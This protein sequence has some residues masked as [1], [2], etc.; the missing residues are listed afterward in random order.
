MGGGLGEYWK[1]KYTSN[2]LLI[3]M[4]HKYLFLASKILWIPM[5]KKWGSWPLQE[6]KK[7]ELVGG[8]FWDISCQSTKETNWVLGGKCQAEDR[9]RLPCPK[10]LAELKGRSLP[11]CLGTL[12]TPRLQEDFCGERASKCYVTDERDLLQIARMQFLF[13]VTLNNTV[14]LINIKIHTY[15]TGLEKVNH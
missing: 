4:T 1:G 3:S 14:L 15:T 2:H 9:L 10:S 6:R 7:K 12:N 5:E 8:K 11:A 13:D